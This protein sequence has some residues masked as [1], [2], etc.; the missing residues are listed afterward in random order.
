MFLE[1]LK[2]L[3]VTPW[4]GSEDFLKRSDEGILR[5]AQDA[6]SKRGTVRVS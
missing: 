5:L 3:S 6:D 1:E 4:Q 2:E